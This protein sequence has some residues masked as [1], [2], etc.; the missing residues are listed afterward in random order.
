M[1]YAR[2][3]RPVDSITIGTS[4][5]CGS[6]VFTFTL[7]TLLPSGRLCGSGEDR[8]GPRHDG[9][10]RGLAIQKLEGLFVADSCSYPIEAPIPCQT[11][12]HCFR[13]LFGLFCQR[14]PLLIQLVI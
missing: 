11:S 4:I 7:S 9:H 1:S 12:A 3:P 8:N 5:I 10:L 14:F 2:S 13:G 6:F